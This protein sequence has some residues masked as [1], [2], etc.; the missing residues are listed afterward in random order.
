LRR[1]PRL[2]DVL[3]V[4]IMLPRERF[5]DREESQKVSL[6]TAT[7]WTKSSGARENI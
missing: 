5:L 6:A 1:Y 4:P 7:T 2:F 3:T